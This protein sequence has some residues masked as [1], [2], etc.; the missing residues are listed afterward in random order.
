MTVLPST[1]L[2]SFPLGDKRERR[3]LGDYSVEGQNLLSYLYLDCL[4]PKDVDIDP[5]TFIF[6]DTSHLL[7]LNFLG[8]SLILDG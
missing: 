3:R 1:C 2:L 6:I 5:G 7:V 8:D 4:F